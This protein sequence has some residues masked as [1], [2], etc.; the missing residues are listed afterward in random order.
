[1]L[2]LSGNLSLLYGRLPLLDRVDA[3][4]DAGFHYVETWWPFAAPDPGQEAVDEFLTALDKRGLALRG[5]NLFAGDMAAGARGLLSVPGRVSELMDNLPVVH[6]IA[7]ATGCRIFN[8]LYGHRTAAD[9]PESQD[10]MAIENLAVIG[11]AVADLGGVVVLEALKTPDNGDYPLHSLE[12]ADRVRER[13]REERGTE[14]VALLFD[15]FHLRG[16]GADLESSFVEFATRIAHIQFADYPGRGAP[17]T[18]SIDF[19][20]LTEV[21]ESMGYR[22][23]IGCEFVPGDLHVD[24]NE[25]ARAIF[26]AKGAES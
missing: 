23:L 5:L 15:T 20:K 8:A 3:A 9:T 22:G 6:R 19:A 12:D 2:D 13:V 18:G 25:L 7:E 14:N 4:A 26:G 17:G 1:M 11:A 24:R 21:I 10:A 16:N